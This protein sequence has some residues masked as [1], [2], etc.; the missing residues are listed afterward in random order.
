M[1]EDIKSNKRQPDEDFETYK[2]RV[3]S[4]KARIEHYVKNGNLL[5]DSDKKG[6]RIGKFIKEAK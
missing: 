1:F 4:D 5:W 3:K 6:Q 2:K